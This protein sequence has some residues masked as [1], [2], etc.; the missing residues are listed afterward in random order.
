MDLNIVY[1]GDPKAEYIFIFLHEGLG[2]I[3]QWRNFPAQVCAENNCYGLVY[4]RSGYGKSPGNLTL[5][6]AHYLHEAATELAEVISNIP[7]H[8]KKILYGH[9]DGGSIALIYAAQH[10]QTV[11]AIVTEAAHVIVEMET[12]RGV[13]AALIPYYQGEFDG[14]KKYHGYRYQEVFLAWSSIWLSPAFE[15]WSIENLL[16]QIICPQ[17]IIQGAA[18][19]YGTLKQVK[20][21]EKLTTG[22]SSTFIV[23]DCGHAP[24]K[25]KEKET[26]L[27]VKTFLNGIKGTSHFLPA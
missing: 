16:A 15:K 10:P 8:Y 19:Q 4:D 21:I 17:L 1:I 22:P 14:L 6:T 9:S 20:L 11:Y 3:E 13:K 24:H 27:A 2:S 5:R 18:D 26:L 25:E 7:K 12:I 23:D